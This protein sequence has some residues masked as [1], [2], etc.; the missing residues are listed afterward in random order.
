MCL[1]KKNTPFF[2]DD[3]AQRAFDNIKHALTHSPVIH[4]PNYLKEFLLYIVVFATTIAMVLVQDNLHSQEHVIYYASKNL[5]DSKTYY[6]H[7]EKLALA[8]VIVVQKFHHYIMLRTT[9]VLADQNP[10]YYIL[11]RQVLRGKYSHWIVIL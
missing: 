10:M 2:W 1:L 4:P 6:S 9:I 3:Q 11:T 5:I 7:V 8:M